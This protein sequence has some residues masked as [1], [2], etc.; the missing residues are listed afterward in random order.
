MS[1]YKEICRSLR[2]GRKVVL[3]TIVATSG[4]TPAPS[5]SRMLIYPDE[6]ASSIGTVGGGCLDANIISYV[7]DNSASLPSRL[8]EFELNDDTGDTGLNC[9]GKVT[10]LVESLS[11]SM[12]PVYQN[13]LSGREEGSDCVLVTRI[14]SEGATEKTLL[15]FDGRI[16]AGSDLD[17]PVMVTIRES[18]PNVMRTQ[19]SQ[20]LKIGSVEYIMELIQCEPSLII[21][22]GGHIGKAVCQCA[23]LAGFRVTV[24]DDRK[25]FA[26][27]ERFPDAHRTLCESFEEAFERLGL[28]DNGLRMTDGRLQI[29]VVES[30]ITSS[31]YIVIVTRGHRHDERVLELSLRCNPKYIGMIGSRRKVQGVF[32]HL[33]SK[34]VTDAMLSRVHAPI[35]LSI[36]ARTPGE[37]GISIVAELIQERRTAFDGKD[38]HGSRVVP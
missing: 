3:A 25:A 13:L 9:G 1:V 23:S 30:Q 4:S 38:E 36:G 14:L 35:G 33:R 2:E 19:S 27:K 34:G 20:H 17:L 11:E 21:F 18:I 28:T 5:E 10:V 24:V 29:S 37:I 12:L 7:K 31:P 32:D 15:S 8:M 6:G 16:S 22:G 26:N